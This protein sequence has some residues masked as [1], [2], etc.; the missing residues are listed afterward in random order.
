MV[1]KNIQILK[2]EIEMKNI[3][4]NFIHTNHECF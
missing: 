3:R 4:G 1:L 2:Y